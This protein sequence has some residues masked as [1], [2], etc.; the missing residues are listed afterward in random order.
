MYSRDHEAVCVVIATRNASYLDDLGKDVYD[1]IVI[2]DKLELC[3]FLVLAVL[4]TPSS[5]MPAATDRSGLLGSA[6]T[7]C[8]LFACVTQT[9]DVMRMLQ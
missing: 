9:N 2:I 6:A 4:V 1:C 7:V 3:T 5:T 8:S